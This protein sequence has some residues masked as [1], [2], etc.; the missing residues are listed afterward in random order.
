MGPSHLPPPH[1]PKRDTGTILATSHK[2]HA[3]LLIFKF[4]FTE[5]C[6]QKRKMCVKEKK[7]LIDSPMVA[8][9]PILLMAE[10]M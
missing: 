4:H 1:P 8:S 7:G 5:L 3:S 9:R 2:L 6:G 10:N